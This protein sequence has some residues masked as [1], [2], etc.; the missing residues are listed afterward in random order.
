M[1]ILGLAVTLVLLAGMSPGSRVL[2]DVVTLPAAKDTTLVEEPMGLKANGGDP[3][4]YA[5]R[6]FQ[7]ENSIRRALIAFNVASAV[8]PGSTITGVSLRLFLTKTRAGPVAV[9]LHRVLADW[10]EGTAAGSGAGAPAMPGDATWL[11]REYD[12]V[13]WAAHGGDFDSL[14][15]AV[16][17]A[18]QPGVFI[19]WGSTPALVADA[20]SWLDTPASNFGWLLRG[21]EDQVPS[22]KLFD[23]REGFFPSRRPQLTVEFDP[24]PPCDAADANCDGQLDGGDIQSFVAGLAGAAGCSAC[25]GDVNGDQAVD[26]GDVAGLVSALLGG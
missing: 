17:I 24:P 26:P 1:R 16:A 25:A 4:I 7:A 6:T 2:G 23:S 19:V 5:G 13:F 3:G 20:Q 18:D 15:S 21:P 9:E 14:V 10:G 11:H 12:T 22:S 8:P